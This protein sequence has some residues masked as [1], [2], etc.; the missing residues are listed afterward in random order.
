LHDAESAACLG[1]ARVATCNLDELGIAIDQPDH[2]SDEGRLAGPIWA[3]K[4]DTLSRSDSQID[5]GEGRVVTV[6]VNETSY[7]E[8]M[9]HLLPPSTPIMRNN[10]CDG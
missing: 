9:F 3:E 6:L 2:V 4:C 7:F 8:Y 10:R 5:S 1:P